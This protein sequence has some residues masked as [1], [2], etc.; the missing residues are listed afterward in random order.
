[1]PDS[2]ESS[3]S[4]QV[5]A[6]KYRP[7]K[8]SEIV[9]Q[10]VFVRLITSALKQKKIGHSFLF[11]GTRGVGKTT[12]ARILAMTLNCLDPEEGDFF[13]PCG[14]CVS[15]ENFLKDKHLDIL[16]IDAA[17]HT[18]VDDVRQLLDSCQ[19]RPMM[20]KCRVFIIDEVH[21]L[22]KSAFNALLKTLEEPPAHVKFIFA[23]TEVHK[24]PATILSRCLRFDLRRIELSVLA[25]HLGEICTREN[26][27]ASQ[28][29]LRMIANVAE[30]SLRDALSILEQAKMLRSHHGAILA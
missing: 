4:Y 13:E 22:S 16:E 14:T 12:S 18:G 5:L 23:T 28:E 17:S 10:D 11:T 29:A 1:M 26:I 6:R 19:Y 3:V 9:G 20:G 8:F 30:G 15:C 7:K 21:M 27:M 24:I 2:T 25:G